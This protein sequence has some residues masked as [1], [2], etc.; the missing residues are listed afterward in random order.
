MVGARTTG[1]R[2][3]ERCEMREGYRPARHPATRKTCSF[4]ADEPRPRCEG[5]P[6]RGRAP[7]GAARRS[8]G[9]RESSDRFGPWQRGRE[10]R[11]SSAV[12]SGTARVRPMAPG[13]TSA[14]RPSGT[15]ATSAEQSGALRIHGHAWL[16]DGSR[17]R[18]ARMVLALDA[19]TRRA[20]GHPPRCGFGRASVEGPWRGR[21]PR[22]D[23]PSG[24]G[25]RRTMVRTQLRSKALKAGLHADRAGSKGTGNGLTA[26]CEGRCE[27]NVKR[28][29]VVVTRHGCG[30]E[31]S[32]EG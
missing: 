16:F 21:K 13:S 27:G 9:N 26:E 30:W 10:C 18:H 4:A 6:S 3:F 1:N 22:E 23:R 19:P 17:K 15:K 12:S 20:G 14:A 11:L 32:F 7:P 24:A 2:P 5:P 28:A 25:I 31:E 29:S 8:T